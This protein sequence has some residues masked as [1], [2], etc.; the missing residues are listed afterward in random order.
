MGDED[1]V[2]PDTS[3][4]PPTR[5]TP[6]L[7]PISSASGAPRVLDDEDAELQA[8]L[9]ASMEGFFIVPPQPSPQPRGLVHSSNLNPQ[10][11]ARPVE[12][13]DEDEEDSDDDM[14][15]VVVVDKG[16][17]KGKEREPSPHEENVDVDE[18]RRR[19]LARFG[20]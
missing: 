1:E 5:R 9:K 11:P 15:E 16:K 14:D 18:M 7:Q 3:N 19:R 6:A 13:D 8:A 20:A 17:G 12:E 4:V 2:D 10:T